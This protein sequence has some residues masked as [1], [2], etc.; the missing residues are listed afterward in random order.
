MAVT[1]N[2]FTGNG[3]TTSFTFT[4][5]YLSPSHVKAKVNGVDTT[6]FTVSG[7]TVTFTTAP[8]SGAA[9]FIYRLTPSDALLA[10]YT[11]GS[12]IRESDLE[13]SFK[14]ILYVSQETEDSALSTDASAIAST[15]TLALNNA[16]AAQ[17]A[18]N[19][20]TATA[21]AATVTANAASAGV[22]A[23]NAA[24]AAASA[25]AAA[26][27][28]FTQ[29]GTGAVQRTVS[30][31][32]KDIISLKDFGAVGN[33]AADDRAALVAALNAVKAR[34][35]GSLYIPKGT[36]LI[37]KGQVFIDCNILIFGDG[38]GAS[39]LRYQDESSDTRADFLNT[40][41]PNTVVQSYNIS[42][43]NLTIQSGLG[44]G[45]SNYTICS[46]LCQ[47]V[48][49]GHVVFSNCEFR[50]SRFFGTVVSYAKS[51]TVTNCRYT[52]IARD[53]LHTDNC[54]NINVTGN[55]FYRV[56]DDS[57]AVGR[58][59]VPLVEN[60]GNSRQTIIA[61]NNFEESQG[62]N[63]SGAKHIAIVGNTFTRVLTRAIEI[64][65][66]AVDGNTA[67]LSVLIANNV[68][69]TV[70]TN[71]GL[72][73][74]AAGDSAK[75][76]FFSGQTPSTVPVTGGYVG[77]ANGSGQVVQPFPYLYTNNTDN[78]PP[79]TGAWFVAIANNVCTRTLAPTSAWS[80]YGFGQLFLGHGQGFHDPVVD[81]TDLV[82]PQQ[83][84]IKI[85][86]S[87]YHAVI[88]GNILQGQNVGIEFFTG[89]TGI[90]LW[91]DVTIRNNVISNFALAGIKHKGR[92]NIHITSNLLDGDPFHV[93]PAR[94][95]GGTWGT[96]WD[97]YF[98]IWADSTSAE[99]TSVVCH[100]NTFRNIGY[101]YQCDSSKV[102][103]MENIYMGYP[104][105][106]FADA[107]NIGIRAWNTG[108]KTWVITDDNPSSSTFKQILNTCLRTSTALPTSGYYLE[109][110]VVWK[111]SALNQTGTAGSQYIVLGWV[112]EITGSNHALNTDWRQIRTLTGN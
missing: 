104:K 75:Y 87:L 54:D 83:A 34:G 28:N 10:D 43:E 68:I 80:N 96:G 69:D 100:N 66:G 94:A 11:A 48:T 38:P 63:A 88:Q 46:H 44:A 106:S 9:V 73:A 51:V 23:A 98:G 13:T 17:T 93:H 82:H 76:I 4:F 56:A 49:S 29:D 59:D 33:G 50:D 53:G 5:P 26:A 84:G 92:G 40:V 61:N 31:K 95:S 22:T 21:N 32:L 37:S 1:Q 74:A 19:A 42:L 36:Y 24:A 79:A 81:Y 3:S 2:S 99:H 85:E 64:G 7:S 25:S 110:M 105:Q 14:Q 45:G 111:D 77:L 12:A 103:F 109:D 112:R 18:A 86:G 55:Y 91:D 101:D 39:V 15:A 16:A 72:G 97:A 35:G 107:T 41:N 60:S 102:S 27:T 20:A 70:F 67:Q 58:L 6:D 108:P 57:V 89:S 8:S 30:S 52:M 65:T 71:F 90:V 47:F 78:N 62:I